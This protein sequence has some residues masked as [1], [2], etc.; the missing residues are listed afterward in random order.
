MWRKVRS[1]MCVL[2]TTFLIAA[3]ESLWA[4]PVMINFEGFGDGTIL[5]NEYFDLTFSNTIILRAQYSLDE[6]EFPPYSGANIASDNNGPMRIDF[7]QPVDQLAG[8]FTYAVPL[9][10]QAFSATSVLLGSV[11]SPFSNNE[12]I[13][14]APPDPNELLLLPFNGI[15]Y[16]TFT[17]ASSGGSFTLDDLTFTPSTSA[18][19]PTPVPEPGAVVLVLTGIAS[20]TRARRHKPVWRLGC[21]PAI[22]VFLN[23][24]APAAEA[25]TVGAPEITPKVIKAGTST[26]VTVTARI[27]DPSVIPASVLLQRVDPTGKV[28]SIEGPMLS[29]AAPNPT[30]FRKEV[31]LTLAAGAQAFYRVSA[32]FKGQLKRLS[33][34]QGDRDVVASVSAVKELLS[35]YSPDGIAK[36]I[37]RNPEVDSA[38]EFVRRLGADD[39]KQNWILMT[40]TESL[41][42]GTAKT[43]RV[44]LRNKSA[45][46]ILGVALVDAP[47][48]EAPKDTIEYIHFND[49]TNTFEFRLINAKPA[50]DEDRV[51]TSSS[52][53]TCHLGKTEGVRPNWD[54]YD[55][56]GGALPFNRDRI[57]KDSAEDVAIRRLLKDLRSDRIISQLD[58]PAI[59]VDLP[60]GSGNYRTAGGMLRDCTGDV[61][62]TYD[63]N[64][65]GTTVNPVRVTYEQHDR[66]QVTF[67]KAGSTPTSAAVRQGGAFLTM[68]T[69]TRVIDEDE[70]RGVAMFDRLSD[71]NA[72]RVTQELL[73]K[74]RDLVDI[75]PIALAIAKCDINATNLGDYAPQA[76]LDALKQFHGM[77]FAD[78]RQDTQ[79]RQATLPS[80]KANYQAENLQ[81]IPDGLFI[82]N[83]AGNP[84]DA[85]AVSQEVFQRSK[86]REIDTTSTECPDD[87]VD[88]AIVRT[89]DVVT[90]RMVDRELYGT[91]TSKIAL[92][93]FFL[94]PAGVPVDQWTM[95]IDSTRRH[96]SGTY[97]FG[98]VFGNPYL[99]TIARMLNDVELANQDGSEKKKGK[100][101]DELKRASTSWFDFAIKSNPPP[102]FR[103]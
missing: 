32:G 10:L 84:D 89:M 53:K 36:F 75:R 103:R 99:A 54:A 25:Q 71:M 66:G 76:A 78:L 56:W 44:I 101:C 102:Y 28:L 47:D 26:K 88:P 8:R 91:S 100:D 23:V 57:Y 97:T 39:F 50:I 61:A 9:T 79:N 86:C 98:D 80:R 48:G 45:D 13:S 6:F 29:L 19:Q 95:S 46:T 87:S 81:R 30:V 64:D 60:S 31:D 12:A 18:P 83:A 65:A 17:G 85:T 35:D 63:Y 41:Q 94:E 3:P 62:I 15:S 67:P 2:F 4:A 43:P 59:G 92:F 33:C 37:E 20:L 77:D 55:S 24:V 82:A 58:L 34:G 40:H 14:G 90:T 74:P 42:V 72:K 69:T 51:V 73:D 16:V 21:L 11:D 5:T 52:C 7:A 22:A 68:H 27:A 38:A 70:G 93:R 49:A 96:H 1:S